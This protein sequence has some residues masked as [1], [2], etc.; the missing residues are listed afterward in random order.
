M[1]HAPD[2]GS[3][4]EEKENSHPHTSDGDDRES[5]TH[6]PGQQQTEKEG[7][8]EDGLDR[9][10]TE[11]L[12]SYSVAKSRRASEISS[13]GTHV[14]RKSSMKKLPGSNNASAGTI[15]HSVLKMDESLMMG[16]AGKGGADTSET[17]KTVNTQSLWFDSNPNSVL[18]ATAVLDEREAELN[19]NPELQAQFMQNQQSTLIS[20]YV[21]IRAPSSQ[22]LSNKE[23]V[24]ERQSNRRSM[25]E[26]L[27]VDSLEY[28]KSHMNLTKKDDPGVD[29]QRTSVMSISANSNGQ[30]NSGVRDEH[31]MAHAASGHHLRAQEEQQTTGQ[32]KSRSSTLFNNKTAHAVLGQFSKLRLWYYTQIQVASLDRA[33]ALKVFGTD[34][35]VAQEQDRQFNAQFVSGVYI[36]HPY[37]KF[38]WKWDLVIVALLIFTLILL[39]VHLA[40]FGDGLPVGWF[41]LNLFVDLCFL[42]DVVFNFR[43]GYVMADHV[44]LERSEIMKHYIKGWFIIDLVSAFPIDLIFEFIDSG[45]ENSGLLRTTRLLKFLRLSKLLRI[46]RIT[47]LLRYIHRWQDT[48]NISTSELRMY[49][50]VFGMLVFAHWDG[51]M[52]FLIAFHMDFPSDSWVVLTGIENSSRGVQYAWSLF[53]ALSQMLC[54]GYGKQPPASTTDV[55]IVTVSMVIGASL[56]ALFIGHMSSLMQSVDFPGRMYNQ[57]LEEINE[58]L[59]YS[60][61][62]AD[63]KQEVRDY[64]EHKWSQR[65]WFDEE[66]ILHEISEPLRKKIKLFNCASLVQKVPFFSEAPREF[67]AAVVILLRHYVYQPG[68]IIMRKGQIGKEMY[69]ITTGRVDVLLP[70]D[71]AKVAITLTDGDYFGEIAVLA[72]THSRRMATLRATTYC[73]L[74]ALTRDDMHILEHDFPDT[75]MLLHDVAEERIRKLNEMN[76]NPEAISEESLDS[77][78]PMVH[79]FDDDDEDH[80]FHHHQL[81]LDSIDA[82][83]LSVTSMRSRKHVKGSWETLDTMDGRNVPSRVIIATLKPVASTNSNTQSPSSKSSPNSTRAGI[84]VKVPESIKE[85]LALGNSE[86]KQTAP[87]ISIRDTDKNKV[88]HCEAIL[89]HEVLHLYTARDEE[90][91][92]K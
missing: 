28:A 85:L 41:V 16:N 63:V 17:K 86:F 62:P 35:A 66:A 11:A 3:S 61:I 77:V 58:Y 47:R 4:L 52:Q 43:T 75:V 21:P 87:F 50:L 15:A 5:P 22:V 55:A 82:S 92:L 40:F 18:T 13:G 72:K 65:K 88:T 8:I 12:S 51:C 74:W 34:N 70:D 32:G 57:H 54:I 39:P 78:G 20:G 89:N 9:A 68:D 46:L 37:S 27:G 71:E 91:L 19:H 1:D 25:F 2:P 33:S 38:R 24:C 31:S 84:R 60:K 42:L 79:L 23:T 48:L 90:Q 80:P 53:A 7:D 10:P 26:Q 59:R 67:V 29:F 14:A 36:I 83:S 73:D 30:M 44:V 6:L 45:S 81:L 69:F 49:K 64:F 76:E 56:F